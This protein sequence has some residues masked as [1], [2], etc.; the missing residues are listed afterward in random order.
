MWNLFGW[1]EGHSYR[2]LV[3][4]SFITSTCLLMY[5]IS[6]RLFWQN[7]K[8]PRWLSPLK[9]RFSA[10]WLLEFPQTKI[11][12]EREETSDCQWDSGKYNEVADGYWENYVRS[13]GAYFEEDWG[14]IVLCTMV[15]VSCIFFNK[16]LS[17]FL[18][19]SW[20]PSGQTH[21]HTNIY[22]HIHVCMG[23]HICVNTH[24]VTHIHMHRHGWTQ[25]CTWMHT[26]VCTCRRV[27]I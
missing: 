18:L 17:F 3:I 19:H 14:I 16:C 5:H 20:K 12:F 26:S 2:Q 4:G 1:L 10:L 23:I 8:S 27:H 11:T 24:M 22:K 15:L 13:Q 21:T 7:I 6:C 25:T 9:P